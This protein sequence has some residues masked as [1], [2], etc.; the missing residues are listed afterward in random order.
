VRRLQ[1]ALKRAP[2]LI[3]LLAVSCARDP[4]P[5]GESMRGLIAEREEAPVVEVYASPMQRK[6]AVW[7]NA[8]RTNG[9]PISRAIVLFEISATPGR[10]GCN[11]LIDAVYSAKSELPVA[12]D[13]DIQEAVSSA[14]DQLSQAGSF[15]LQE[16][17]G[18]Q[19]TFLVIGRSGIT[20]AE[21]LLSERY[22][23]GGVPG[24]G[25]PMDGGTTIGERAVAFA[26]EARR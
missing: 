26:R 19:D 6:M 9:Q 20:L 1:E 12:P 18:L 5:Q 10:R 25:E 13:P 7:A 15:C 4:A 24:L 17:V 22:D 23:Q 3:A 2:A 16:K 11:M 8:Y 21:S 14:L